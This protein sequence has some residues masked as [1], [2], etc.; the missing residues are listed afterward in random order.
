MCIN[1]RTPSPPPPPPLPPAPP[2]PTPPVAPLPP[3][4]PLTTEVNPAVLMDQDSRKD[5]GQQGQG[6]GDL[7]IEPD[8]NIN[9][10]QTAGTGGLNA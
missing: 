4:D 2:P 5:E 1:V 3:P 9:T 10:G 8:P 6:T 7:R